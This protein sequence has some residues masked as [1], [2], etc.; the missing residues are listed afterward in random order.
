MAL[1]R[2]FQFQNQN[3]LVCELFLWSFIKIVDTFEMEKIWASLNQINQ[4]SNRDE[5]CNIR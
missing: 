2:S 4:H 1:E 3:S 5:K